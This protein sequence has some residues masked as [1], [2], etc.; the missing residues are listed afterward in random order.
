MYADTNRACW[1]PWRRRCFRTPLGSE[2]LG[3]RR[4]VL[5][6]S[7]VLLH[8][9]AEEIDVPALPPCRCAARRR[10]V[11]SR[12]RRC[13][14]ATRWTVHTAQRGGGTRSAS[15]R[16]EWQASRALVVSKSSVSTQSCALRLH[17]VADAPPCGGTTVE[18]EAVFGAARSPII[19]LITPGPQVMMFRL[20]VAGCCWCACC[21]RQ[22]QT[23]ANWDPW[24]SSWAL[25]GDF[26]L[27]GGAH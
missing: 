6:R 25:V 2:R 19:R 24:C 21:L 13:S 1:L 14:S 16:S 22:A 4:C 7:G 27:Q 12:A 15:V 9:A 23:V 17:E 3:A 26:L 5:R 11:L 10:G 18:L 20:F 8:A